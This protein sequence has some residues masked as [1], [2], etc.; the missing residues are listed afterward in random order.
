MTEHG[1]V[2]TFKGMWTE[3]DK[4]DPTKRVRRVSRLWLWRFSWHAKTYTGG[5]GQTTRAAARTLGE[6][7]KTEVVA[8]IEEDPRKLTF[9]SLK[10]MISAEASL[11][12]QHT[13]ASARGVIA[14][15]SRF[16]EDGTRAVDITRTRLIEY[17]NFCKEAPRSAQPSTIKLDLTY[18]RRVMR[19]CHEDARLTRLPAFPKIRVEARQET[20]RPEEL[21]RILSH[22]PAWLQRYYLALDETS[23]RPG[24]LRSR[25]RTDVDFEAGFLLLD[26]NSSKTRRGRT[27]PLTEYLRELLKEQ[28]AYVE[29]VEL[30]TERIVPWL[31]CQPSGAPLGRHKQRWQEACVAAGFG[32]L[33]GR[34]GPWSGAKVSHDVRRTTMRR[35]DGL[36]LPL[37]GRM[38]AAGHEAERSHQVYLGGDPETLRAMAEA[39]DEDRRRRAAGDP[40]VAA[41]RPRDE[42]GTGE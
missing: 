40:K 34:T 1:M 31:F 29:A 15:L 39:L 38:A 25:K 28:I 13:Q 22:L 27:F 20:I 18:L 36:M 14:R 17:V 21:R 7:R 42:T 3:R 4:N 11:Q 10:A 5:P 19:L 9:L 12:T 8:G 30:A 35:W 24:E 6:K 41:F 33:E 2:H 16:F 23:W 26:A 37:G 32:K